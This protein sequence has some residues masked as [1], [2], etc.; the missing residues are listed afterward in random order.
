[1]TRTLRILKETP[2]SRTLALV[3]G[4]NSFLLANLFVR[5]PALQHMLGLSPAEIGLAL[6]GLSAGSILAMLTAGR[7]VARLGASR[8]T[9]GAAFL[10]CLVSPLP[11]LAGNVIELSAALTVLGLVNG[12][13]AVAMNATAA[14]VEEHRKRPVMASFHAMFSLG[15][16]AGAGTGSAL[17]ALG[18]GPSAH[19]TLLAGATALLVLTRRGTLP[20]TAAALPRGVE[21][22]MTR[23]RGRLA[24]LAV[25]CLATMLCEG[26]ASD[27]SALYL[28]H[29]LGA[30]QTLAAMGYVFYATGMTIGRLRGDTLRDRLGDAVLA[31]GGALLAALGLGTALLV[32]MAIPALLGFLCLGLGLSGIVPIIFRK[33]TA[34]PG[35][36]PATAIS[37]VASVGFAGFLA[38]PPLIALLAQ[39]IGLTAALGVV[40]ILA[41]GVA[42]AGPWALGRGVEPQ[43]PTAQTDKRL[44]Q[45]TG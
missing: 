45:A 14:I 27:W 42:A 43:P 32:G 3:F 5:L 36:A 13:V 11:A 9:W 44:A 20:A 38:G 33:A 7:L 19:L 4:L 8:L 37:A 6:T 12:C 22:G 18:L 2:A 35:V 41:L 21:P 17:V 39:N 10:L 34:V 16:I 23:P 40:P 26:A 30:P 28:A 24:V 15:G 1:M 31:S 29:E 25:I